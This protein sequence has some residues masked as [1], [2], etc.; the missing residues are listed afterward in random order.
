[1]IAHHKKSKSRHCF[2]AGDPVAPER[3]HR[4]R[5]G[6][7]ALREI[8]KYQKSSDLLLR[9]LPFARLVCLCIIHL[10][11]YLFKN[12]CERLRMNLAY[13]PARYIGKHMLLCA[14]KKQQ[15]PFWFICLKIRK[16]NLNSSY[17]SLS[18]DLFQQKLGCHS[19][20]TRHHYGQGYAT[21][22]THS[23]P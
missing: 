22:A 13:R 19:R 8:R 21:S 14:F 17:G 4:Y 12:R 3:K 18:I 9:K 11:I 1:M 15:R 20:E 16:C 10:F 5:P 23:W 7:V 6:T 2:L